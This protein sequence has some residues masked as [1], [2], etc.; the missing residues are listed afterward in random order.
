MAGVNKATLV[1]HTAPG[2][3]AKANY[4]WSGPLAGHA[5]TSGWVQSSSTDD[6]STSIVSSAVDVGA[7]LDYSAL[8][9]VGYFFS[10]SGVGNTAP[11]RD[12]IALVNGHLAK[13][14]SNGYYGQLTYKIANLKLGTSY[15]ACNLD[16]APGETADTLVKTNSSIIGGAYYT[17][18]STVVLATEWTN[19]TSKNQAGGK[20]NENSLAF[21]ASAGF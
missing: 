17:I 11:M 2:F 14:R 18:A 5:W 15:G 16:L 1:Q 9:L 4:D 21:G 12:G 19:T 6:G 8:S 13:R 7:R 3:M 10:G 20:L